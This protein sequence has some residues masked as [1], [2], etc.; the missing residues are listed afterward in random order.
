MQT[1][2]FAFIYSGFSLVTDEQ[3]SLS[4][5][6]QSQVVGPCPLVGLS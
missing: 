1:K 2:M 5:Q 6:P 4:V 3:V